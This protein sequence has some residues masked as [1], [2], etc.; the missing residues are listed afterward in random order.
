MFVVLNSPPMVP[1]EPAPVTEWRPDELR[2]GEEVR[3][4]WG[5]DDCYYVSVKRADGATQWYVGHGPL[6]AQTSGDHDPSVLPLRGVRPIRVAE[7]RAASAV[8]WGRL[9]HRAGTTAATVLAGRAGRSLR[10][11]A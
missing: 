8:L 3:A 10:W 4:F 1:C 2:G 6:S 11:Q 7:S 5:A 9:S